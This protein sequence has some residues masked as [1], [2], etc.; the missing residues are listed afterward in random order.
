[1]LSSYN[2]RK[3]IAIS[4]LVLKPKSGTTR[5]R[6][7]VLRAAKSLFADIGDCVVEFFDI[8]ITKIVPLITK[9]RVHRKLDAV[10]FSLC[11]EKLKIL[12]PSH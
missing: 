3:I 8:V 10:T 12:K 5:I 2:S 9:K 11:E 1:M 7:V 4:D 6:T